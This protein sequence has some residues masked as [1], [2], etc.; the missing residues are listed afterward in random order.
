[1]QRQS[2][3]LLP[4]FIT[5]ILLGAALGVATAP[6]GEAPV[7]RLTPGASFAPGLSVAPGST[8]EP[9]AEPTASTG[10]LPI[11]RLPV[12]RFTPTAGGS[13]ALPVEVPPASE[14]GIGLSGRRTL[15]GRGMLFY[16]PDGKGNSGFW[17]KNT[18]IDLEIAFV[19]TSMTVI[20]VLTMKAD[21]ETVHR[22]NQPYL[23]AIEAPVG[24]FSRTGIGA[25]AKVEFQFD[26]ASL[27]RP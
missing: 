2:R 25:G 15:D 11:E 7:A 23:A 10:A 1:M 20:T 16:Y 14:Y 24:Y 22:P 3:F 21:T 4:A 26:V 6:R 27:V 12:V 17:M 18:H 8:P 9:P 5:A 19:D 13:V